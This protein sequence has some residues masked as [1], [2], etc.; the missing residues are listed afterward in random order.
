MDF[1]SINN[2]IT[3]ITLEELVIIGIILG[4]MIYFVNVLVEKFD[5]LFSRLFF[6]IV[7]CFILYKTYLGI[8]EIG[9]L[10]IF[11]VILLFKTL[12]LFRQS[13]YIFIKAKN[14]IVELI[15]NKSLP[16]Q[17]ACFSKAKTPEEIEL[18]KERLKLEKEKHEKEM[19][20]YKKTL[21]KLDDF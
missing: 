13:S 12:A 2:V 17:E 5:S 15:E 18:E 16:Q 14:K 1:S 3:N 6:V 7:S 9:T 20:I 8:Y 21:K 11:A 19:E 10:T 4:F